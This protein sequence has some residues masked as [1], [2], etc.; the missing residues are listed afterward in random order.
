VLISHPILTTIPQQQQKKIQGFGKQILLEQILIE[1][2]SKLNVH[3]FFQYI[4]F[5]V[6]PG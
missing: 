1:T 4:Q 2:K 5:N 6:S 3:Y